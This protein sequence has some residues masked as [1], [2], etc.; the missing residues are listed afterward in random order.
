MFK[1]LIW[2]IVRFCRSNITGDMIKKLKNCFFKKCQFL[3]FL[4]IWQKN[5]KIHKS[6]PKKSH[7][8]VTTADIFL[9]NSFLKTI[10]SSALIICPH[11]GRGQKKPK[12]P[13][14]WAV[15]YGELRQFRDQN[16]DQRMQLH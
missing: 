2:G 4:T 9:Q 15:S 11:T 3:Q 14:S 6:H 10:S 12:L 16:R 5:A 1:A 8:F 13:P 7:L